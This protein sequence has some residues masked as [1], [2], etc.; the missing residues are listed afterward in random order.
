MDTICRETA[1][2]ENL[3]DEMARDA[4]KAEGLL[5]GVQKWAR[6]QLSSKASRASSGVTESAPLASESINN[7]IRLMSIFGS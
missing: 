3:C 1:A 4:L 6:G 7:E 2:P 5:C